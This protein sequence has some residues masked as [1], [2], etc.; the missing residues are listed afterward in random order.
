VAFLPQSSAAAF[1]RDSL[2]LLGSSEWMPYAPAIVS[3]HDSIALDVPIDLADHAIEWLIQTLTRPIPLLNGLRIG[4]EVKQGRSWRRWRWWHVKTSDQF[5]PRPLKD[6][7][8][9]V[10]DADWKSGPGE[11]GGG[12]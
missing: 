7:E 5:K 9:Y 1:M 2:V 11:M 12:E 6:G 4:C 10:G 8:Y 3:I